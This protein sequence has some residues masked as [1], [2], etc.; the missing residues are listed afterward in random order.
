MKSFFI[1]GILLLFTLQT[2]A[3]DSLYDL[4]CEHL[5]SPIG[6]DVS[7]PRLSWK[8]QTGR[9]NMKQSSYLI[10]VDTDSGSV[11][12]GSGSWWNSGKVNKDSILVHYQ[13]KP[14]MP[15]T[16]YFWKA[17]VWDAAG[18]KYDAAV[19]SF[20]TGRMQSAWKGT[21]ITDGIDVNKRPA[22]YFRKEISIE[23]KLLSARA[24]ISAGGLFELYL[25]GKQVGD[26]RLNPMYTRFDRR[27]L[28]VTHDITNL[29]KGGKNAV[30][31]I[32]GNG[33]FN[34]QST[35]VWFF[36]LATWR[37]RPKFIMDIKLTYED[38]S[39]EWIGT[40]PSWK[41]SGGA[42]VFNS[43]YTAEHH[44][45]N[46]TQK[47]WNTP[48][49]NDSAWR[50]AIV[51]SAPSGNL[52]SQQLQ[53]VRFTDTLNPVSMRKFSDTLYL[54]NLGRNISGISKI[55]LTGPAGTI[56]RLKHAERLD[57]NGRADQSNIDLHY[58]PTDN[59]DPFHTDIFTLSGTGEEEFMPLFNYKGFQYVEVS[60]SAP[61]TLTQSSLTGYFMHSDVPPIGKINSSNELLNRIWSATNNSY[62]S[63]LFGYPTDCPQ[64]E[65][66]G[67]TGDAHIASETGL[68]N[69]DAITVYEKWI[70]D[71][72]DEQQPNGILPSIIPTNQW[73]YDWGNGPDW[74]STIAIIPW[75]IYQFYGDKTLLRNA[76]ENIK[77]YVDYIDRTYPTGL[78]DWGLGD[79]IP[80]KSEAT[81]ELTSSIYYFVDADILAKA[82]GI[83][84]YR[85]D[86]DRY[87][88]L[89]DKI[90]HAINEKYL[91]RQTGIY[92]KGVQTEL[93]M[94]LQWGIVPEDV[95][96]KVA[97]NLYDR[98][99]ADKGLDVGLLGSKAIL[100][101]LSENGYVQK[102]YELAANDKYPSWGYWIRNGATTLFEN[103]RIEG[104]NDLSLNH[105]MF[106]EIGA[107]MFKAL[108]GI[109]IDPSNPGFKHV[110]IQP[111]FVNGLNQFE[112]SHDGPYGTITS[113][114]KRKGKKIE[115]KVIIPANSTATV[116]TAKNRYEV[117]SGEHVFVD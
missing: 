79:W 44:D 32:L 25:N 114:W 45:A 4:S 59:K 99:V 34:H 17:I 39:E 11:A 13:G 22:G 89:A 68:Y 29:L 6:I 62:L 7:A 103:W 69:F 36:H 70:N 65:K 41:T 5:E 92:A 16:K 38:G 107:W 63:N 95:K 3:Q 53:P 42:I 61:I 115:L 94:P 35:A 60:A 9:K 81:K 72:K 109:R 82:A 73:G 46:K 54:F 47:G 26:Q 33:W 104:N 75:N 96:S 90:K 66:N 49:F 84:G 15:Q 19:T 116:V 28:Y 80:I 86:Q 43:I 64:R 20:E 101:A 78:T 30:G 24:Y 18:N 37:A 106:G 111:N 112:A 98:V 102:A 85:D 117:G 52:V 93:A 27:N 108:A 23:K 105:I 1:S 88:K 2:G 71:H 77:R 58:R 12:N 74:T 91:N 8:I 21:W 48:S 113:S 14:L 55:K 97:K 10:L 31:V 100:N 83:L 56:I 87:E 50:H 76:Y 40:D 67:W 110:I 57:S 51:T